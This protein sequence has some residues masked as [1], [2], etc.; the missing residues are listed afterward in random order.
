MRTI[1]VSLRLGVFKQKILLDKIAKVASD[2]KKGK[3]LKA[4]EGARDAIKDIKNEHWVFKNLDNDKK[5]A[6]TNIFE[7]ILAA[8]K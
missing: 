6:L 7:S 5:Q 3:Q 4:D 2:L 1:I 8:I